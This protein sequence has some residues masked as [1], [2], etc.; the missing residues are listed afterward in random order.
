MFLY[1]PIQR[2]SL[3]AYIRRGIIEYEQVPWRIEP[4]SKEETPVNTDAT[5]LFFTRGT[6]GLCT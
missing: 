1:D 5:S 2:A 4:N 6:T 3:T